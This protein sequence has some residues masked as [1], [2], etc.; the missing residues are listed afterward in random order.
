MLMLAFFSDYNLFIY[1][2]PPNPGR[3]DVMFYTGTS[4]IAKSFN[5]RRNDGIYTSNN[6]LAVDIINRVQRKIGEAP[7]WCGQPRTNTTELLSDG[8]CLFCQ[9]HCM[10][11]V[12]IYS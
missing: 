5:R 4:A 10:R 8:Q 2:D 7:N 6:I 12:N 1:M 9:L 3:R 11:L